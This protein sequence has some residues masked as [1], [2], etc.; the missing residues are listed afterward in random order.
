M[1]DLSETVGSFIYVE[2]EG[3]SRSTRHRPHHF[4]RRP[5]ERKSPQD[6]ASHRGPRSRG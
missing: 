1:G 3:F 6:F 2:I 4:P 5:S